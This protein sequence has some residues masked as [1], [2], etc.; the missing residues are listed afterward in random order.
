MTVQKHSVQGVSLFSGKQI[1]VGEG[2]A[3]TELFLFLP[4]ILQKCT[5][6]SLVDPKDIDITPVAKGSALLPALLHSFLRKGR[7]SGRCH[8]VAATLP[9]LG[10][11]A[12]SFPLHPLPR[13]P[14]LI[15][16]LLITSF[17]QYPV[18]IQPPLKESFLSFT[19]HGHLL[20]SI[21]CNT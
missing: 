16:P 12:T 19:A 17:P 15:F 7:P 9:P 1:C 3:C 18:N 11:T 8:T 20:F 13:M 21:L 2:L 6:K 10:E 4:I 5:L 14:P